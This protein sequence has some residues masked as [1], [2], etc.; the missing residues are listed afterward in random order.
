MI[1]FIRAALGRKRAV[2]FTLLFIIFA[3]LASWSQI[4]KESNPDISIPVI[5]VS[6]SLEGVSPE[7]SERLLIRPMEEQ[8]STIEGVKEM[9]A[10]GFQGGGN[11]VLEFRAGFDADKAL[12][13]VREAVD[14]AKPDLPEDADEPVVTEVNFSLF[15]VLVVTLAGDVP[16]RTL[17]RLVKDLQDRIEDIGSVLEARRVGSRDEQVEVIVDSL[18]VESYGL[19]ANDI[20]AF[21]Q[22]SGKLVAAGNLESGGGR[23]AVKVPGL[24]E[25]AAD[26]AEMPLKVSGDAVVRVRDVAEVRR[27]FKDPESFARLNGKNAIALEIVKRTG[28]NVIDTIEA[29]KK[30]VEEERKNWPAGVVVGYTRDTSQEIRNMLADLQNNL[31]SAV[32]L[33]M[34]VCV[35]ALGLFS[36]SLVGI[37]IPGSFL[38]GILVLHTM[39]TTLNIVVL[40]SLILVVGMLV[41]GAVVVG[42]YADRKM[43]EGMD[44]ADAYREAAVKMAWPVISSIVT[45]MVAFFPLLV[46]PG[47]VGQF[48]KYMPVTIV[49]TLTASLIMALVFIPVIGSMIGRT[50]HGEDKGVAE[51]LAKGEEP[52]LLRLKGL[53]GF[54]MRI[55]ARALD[56]PGKVMALA[57]AML[58]G[59]QVYYGKFGNGVEFFPDVEPEAASVLIHARGNLSVYEQDVIVRKV[60]ERVLREPGLK[61]VYA[62]TGGS[63]NSDM[64]EDVIGNIQLEFDSWRRRKPANDILDDIRRNTADI[65][66]IRI[67]TVKEEGGPHGGKAVQ[68]QLRSLYPE[69]LPGAVETLRKGLDGI[70][71][72]IDAEDSRPLPGIEWQLTID[73]AQAAKFGLDTTSIGQSVRLVTNG[74]KIS[75]YRP[76]DSTDEIDIVVRYPQDQRSLDALDRIRIETPQGSVPASN[77]VSKTAEPRLG[78]VERSDGYRIMTVKADVPPETNADAK[79]NEIRQWLEKTK[80]DPRV[81]IVFKGEDEDQKEAQAFLQKAFVAALFMILII[82]V[83]QFDSFYYTFLILSAVIMST[84]GVFLGLLITGRPFGIVM[85]GIGVIALAGAIVTNNIVLIDTFA[86]MKKE[87]ASTVRNMILRTGA[88]RMRPV[89]LTAATTALGLVPMVFQVNIDFLAREVTVN[90]PSTQWWVDLATA[91][92]FGMVFATPLTLIVTPCALMFQEKVVALWRKWRG[93]S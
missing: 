68:V 26:V 36:A 80:W 77:F 84:I 76:D 58:I 49:I 29:V 52:D 3:G 89:L 25:T 39:G 43:S 60:E 62:R 2:L 88:Q 5:Y 12:D 57:L 85:T 59:I 54:Y 83:I 9:R 73:K 41:D 21:F 37:A 4:P 38:A 17:N 47:M 46:W 22:R 1:T 24:F 75:A 23:F 63:G 79:I 64:A 53:T 71:G 93:R 10:T 87:A 51:V 72:F 74:L 32:I 30:T 19:S 90:A 56:H 40:F 78:R 44:R 15:P 13:D 70:G 82:L 61:N 81:Q 67:E 34:I 31:V 14:K 11:V 35:A 91:I 42:E 28:E 18:R 69:L 45:H 7:D 86:Q 55:L 65:P 48:M 27:N 33:V 6:V 16:E 50:D 8:L 66:G 20:I 92:A